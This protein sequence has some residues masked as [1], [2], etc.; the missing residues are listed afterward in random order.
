[1]HVF[2]V[3]LQRN[4]GSC[5]NGQDVSCQSLISKRDSDA[6]SIRGAAMV[7]LIGRW[8]AS[9]TCIWPSHL[10]TKKTRLCTTHT[11]PG[12]DFALDS[13]RDILT[14]VL[15][16][17]RALF[18]NK[19][20]PCLVAMALA[21]LMHVGMF[22]VKIRQLLTIVRSLALERALPQLPNSSPRHVY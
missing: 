9:K 12:R 22:S 14:P 15:D 4:V 7:K 5:G 20:P 1:M 11:S 17:C 3:P 21:S 19:L 13:L 2:D 8:G 10:L 6:Q 16:G 18:A